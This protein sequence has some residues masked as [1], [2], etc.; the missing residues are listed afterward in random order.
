MGGT[1][2]VH[3]LGQTEEEV[4]ATMKLKNRKTV[5]A[6]LAAAFVAVLMMVMP[7]QAQ[8]VER[9]EQSGQIQWGVWV[10]P[11]GC[12]HWMADGGLE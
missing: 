4:V 8:Q 6:G 9:G 7:A 2:S 10:D 12:M 11:D 5:L 3:C 1:Q